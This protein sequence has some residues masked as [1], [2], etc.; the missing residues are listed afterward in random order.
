MSNRVLKKITYCILSAEKCWYIFLIAVFLKESLDS[1]PSVFSRL[2][3]CSQRQNSWEKKEWIE[4][5]ESFINSRLLVISDCEIN[6]LLVH[7]LKIYRSLKLHI[8]RLFDVSF[9]IY[10]WYIF[11]LFSFS[12]FYHYGY[13]CCD[14]K[15]KSSSSPWDKK[16]GRSR[17]NAVN[18]ESKRT[19]EVALYPASLTPKENHLV[20]RC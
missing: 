1:S 7:L 14:W 17:F 20:L 2:H 19:T 4:S 9:R 6:I 15:L 12:F 11:F 3:R 8:H 10:A 13:C 16:N 18:T 5:S